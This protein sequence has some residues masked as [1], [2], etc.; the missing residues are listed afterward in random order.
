MNPAL[1]IGLGKA[2]SA[3]SSILEGLATMDYLDSQI[4]GAQMTWGQLRREKKEARLAT[5]YRVEVAAEDGCP[6]VVDGQRST[7]RPP[8]LATAMSGRASELRSPTAMSTGNDPTEKTS[9]A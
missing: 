6:I 7:S 5:S 9:G 2:A 1:L 8:K 3:G 4:S